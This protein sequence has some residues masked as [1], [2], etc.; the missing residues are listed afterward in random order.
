MMLGFHFGSSCWGLGHGRPFLQVLKLVGSLA[1]AATGEGV[2]WRWKRMVGWC[3]PRREL[4]QDSLGE[5]IDGVARFSGK[6][7]V[8]KLSEGGVAE[9]GVASTVVA[10]TSIL[11]AIYL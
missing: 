4:N 6:N 1:Q 10:R 9:R 11:G 8:A 3:S 2:D 7:S 5:E